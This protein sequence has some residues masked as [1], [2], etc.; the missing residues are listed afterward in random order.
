MMVGTGLGGSQSWLPPPF[1]AACAS[2][3]DCRLQAR[4]PAPLNAPAGDPSRSGGARKATLRPSNPPMCP[5]SS[6]LGEPVF[7][8]ADAARLGSVSLRQLQWWDEQ[9]LVSPRQ[10]D[11]R[12]IYAP[13]Q[14]LEILTV[15]ALRRKGLSLQKIRKV[16]R[17]LRRELGRLGSRVWSAQSQLY[18][19]TDGHSI[20]VDGQPESVLNRI[21]D[22]TKPMY[23]VSLTDMAKQVASEN[24]SSRYRAKQLD[25]F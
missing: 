8:S 22:S 13:E 1:V 23:L 16:L 11:R 24:A 12:R 9:K 7:R 25:L 6:P 17:A 4:W 10:D 20:F 15:A 14:V 2:R 18:L 21:A 3:Q 19:I 5:D